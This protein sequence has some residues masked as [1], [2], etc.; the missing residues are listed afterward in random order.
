[1]NEIPIFAFS[2]AITD[3]ISARFPCFTTG[4]V[5]MESPP[6]KIILPPYGGLFELF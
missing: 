3:T 4:N 2:L 6:S 5:C 1:M